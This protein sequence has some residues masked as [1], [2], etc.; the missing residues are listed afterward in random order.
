[1]QP[2]RCSG[3]CWTPCLITEVPPA[4]AQ[5]TARLPR[6][7]CTSRRLRPSSDKARLQGLHLQL[8]PATLAPPTSAQLCSLV[9]AQGLALRQ[10]TLR[11]AVHDATAVSGELAQALLSCPQLS[12]LQLI[13]AEV[14][15]LPAEQSSQ[16]CSSIEGMTG[17]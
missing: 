3:R 12:S 7:A 13:C 1:M 2:H 9:S 17:L 14:V 4:T 10:L 6:S 16:L 11:E 8:G 5:A 15:Q